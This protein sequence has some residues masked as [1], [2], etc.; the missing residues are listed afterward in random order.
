MYRTSKRLSVEETIDK[1]QQ[2]LLIQE[3]LRL[4]QVFERLLSVI[5]FLAERNLAFRGSVE[6]IGDSHNGNFLGIIELLGKFDPIIQDHLRRIDSK[7]IQQHY[8]S[9]TIQ[10]E[11][12]NLMGNKIQNQIINRIKLGKYFAIILDCTPDISHQ[13]QMSLTLRYVSDGI[14]PG[15][16]IGIYEQFIKFINVE[17]STGENLYAVLKREINSLGLNLN[18]IRGQGYDNSSNMKGKISGVQAR[19]LKENS[20]AFFTPCACH[21]YNLVLADV[22]KTCPDALTFFGTLQRL[23]VLSSSS[24]KRWSILRKYVKDLSVKPLSDTRWECRIQSVKAVRYQVGEVYDALLEISETSE[25]P[26]VKSNSESLAHL[27][28]DYKFIVSLILWYDLLFQVNFISKELQSDSVD[29]SVALFSFKKFLCWLT[30]YRD[31]GFEQVLVEAK[32]FAE[33][34]E[35]I[36]EFQNKRLR[37]RKKYFIYEVDDE[38]IVNPAELFKIN[39][40]NVVLDKAKQSLQIRFEQLKNHTDLFGFLGKFQK[41]EKDEL[42]KHAAQLEIALTNTKITQEDSSDN[43]VNEKDLDGNILV[44]EMEVLKIILSLEYYGKPYKMFQFLAENDR[45]TAFP[46]LF[47][48]LRIY[49]TIPVTVAS[50]ERT[51][52]RLK[53]IKNY[54]RST[55]TQDRLNSLAILSIE[56]QETKQLDFDSVLED[57]SELKARK[58]NF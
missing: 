41:M 47:I 19:L 20:R 30:K 6:N 32:T 7:E 8:L 3:K 50:G 45:A 54:L 48:A 51:F 42:K 33:D 21:N 17:S 11:L 13:E 10:D 43:F 36:P 56:N 49:L 37:K 23:Y 35:I 57:F 15:S 25:D 39:F 46:N 44:D 2:K 52:S 18:N 14:S 22:V 29:I 1:V 24:T 34:L 58:C 40:F 4:R 16:I 28:K 38:P 55:M 27:I 9:K 53:L 26:Q 31:T 12:V 5:Q